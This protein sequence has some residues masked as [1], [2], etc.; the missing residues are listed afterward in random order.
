MPDVWINL[1]H[2]YFAQGHFQQAVKM[3]ISCLP[4]PCLPDVWINLG[5]T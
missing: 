5:H 4:A 2:T 1:A 3:V